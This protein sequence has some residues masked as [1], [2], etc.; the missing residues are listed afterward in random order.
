M[1]KPGLFLTSW[2]DMTK[3][4]PREHAVADLSVAR[5]AKG[6]MQGGRSPPHP[7]PPHLLSTPLPPTPNPPP[8]LPAVDSAVNVSL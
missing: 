5:P 1:V 3:A 2:Q 8:P 6:S 4:T 7:T